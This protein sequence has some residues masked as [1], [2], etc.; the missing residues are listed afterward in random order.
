MMINVNLFTSDEYKMSPVEF[1]TFIH[2][3]E[4]SIC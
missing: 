4:L 1:E 2:D 3:E